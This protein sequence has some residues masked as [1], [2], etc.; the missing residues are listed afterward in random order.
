MTEITGEKRQLSIGKLALNAICFVIFIGIIGAIL[1]RGEFESRGDPDRYYHYA[2][3][4]ITASDFAPETFA[5]VTGIG[6]DKFFQEKE[7]LFHVLTGIGYRLGN[8]P[9]VVLVALGG[10]ALLFVTL[11]IYN[12]ALLGPLAALFITLFTGLGF[13]RFAYRIFMVRPHVWAMFIL[14]LF[15]ISLI[16]RSAKGCFILSM[17][18]ALLYH[19]IYLPALYAGVFLFCDWY[20]KKTSSSD[21]ISLSSKPAFLVTIAGLTVGVILNPYFPANVLV[22]LTH[23]KIAL[24]QTSLSINHFGGELRPL[25]SSD[26]L[27]Y[28]AGFFLLAF[29]AMGILYSVIFPTELSRKK[30]R[31]HVNLVSLSLLLLITF[32]ISM[33]SPRGTELLVVVA[34]ILIPSIY[35]YFA[36]PRQW[37]IGS[38]SLFI[39]LQ[40]YK[41]HY[42]ISSPLNASTFLQTEDAANDAKIALRDV[43]SGALVANCNWDVSPFILH[44]RSDVRVIDLLDP[45]FLHNHNSDLYDL[46]RKWIDNLAPDSYGL[47]KDGFGADYVFCYHSDMTFR[48]A[49]DPHFHRVFPR[50]S[51][52]T[53]TNR[54]TLFRLADNRLPNFLNNYIISSKFRRTDVKTK[55]T[56]DI[57][58]KGANALDKIVWPAPHI[59]DLGVNPIFIQLFDLIA[60][61]TSIHQQPEDA[62]KETALLE[63]PKDDTGEKLMS[64][65]ADI[66]L[67]DTELKK[68]I[69]AT[70]MTLGGGPLIQT[71]LNGQLIYKDLAANQ[72]TALIRQTIRLKK[73]ISAK[74]YF[75]FNVCTGGSTHKTGIFGLAVAF[76][77]PEEIKVVCDNNLQNFAE[78]NT[79]TSA[80]SPHPAPWCRS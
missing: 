21:D 24:A 28:L 60:H 13:G 8:E 18:F 33:L 65:C 41:N 56:E 67:P 6:W 74:D 66:E 54:F 46:R 55:K 22:G 29:V 69:G 1:V 68:H 77:T 17:V 34:A 39:L 76:W 50:T 15:L 5:Q 43:K 48:L 57:S 27:R 31:D 2:I 25:L 47:M 40:M 38:L 72:D 4:K 70:L 62:A 51:A 14:T 61:E 80:V 79:P 30:G 75:S 10:G 64:Y 73:P 16:R 71:K 59:K 32:M 36:V 78:D 26:F 49:M 35:K 7:F 9:G 19:G 58:V 11:Y 63:A 12:A 53:K 23:L 20:I 37:I 42:V 44:A 52:E 3:S 45:T